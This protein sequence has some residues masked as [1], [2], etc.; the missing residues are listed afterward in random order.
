M[1]I[2]RDHPL[3]VLVATH[4]CPDEPTASDRRCIAQPLRQSLRVTTVLAKGICGSE[5]RF[6]LVS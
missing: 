3:P 5:Y 4:P 2:G 6:F 1:F